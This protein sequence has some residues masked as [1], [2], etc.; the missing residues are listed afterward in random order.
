MCES[1][2]VLAPSE[3]DTG[4]DIWEIS[5]GISLCPTLY[6]QTE[7][8]AGMRKAMMGSINDDWPPGRDWESS[9]D[10]TETETNGWSRATTATPPPPLLPLGLSHRPFISRAV[11]AGFTVRWHLLLYS[12]ARPRHRSGCGV[13]TATGCL[14]L[15]NTK[16][17]AKNSRR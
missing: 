15:T 12:S 9:P 8:E 16:W 7:V 4:A 14:S 5:A 10:Y 6:T 1:A 3:Q 2:C 13:L 11:D 17:G